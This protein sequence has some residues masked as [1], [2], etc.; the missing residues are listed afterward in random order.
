M[1]QKSSALSPSTQT[2]RPPSL[3]LVKATLAIINFCIT[4]TQG[5]K[6]IVSMVVFVIF[7][8]FLQALLELWNAGGLKQFDD[9]RIL[10]LAENAK[11]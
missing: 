4:L 3:F 10:V 2:I 1:N 7:F 8:L 5:V 11:L 9:A 6:Q